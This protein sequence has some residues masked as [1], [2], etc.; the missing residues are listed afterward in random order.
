MGTSAQRVLAALAE[1]A[2]VM[3]SEL[4]VSLE[5][6]VGE[7]TIRRSSAQLREFG[8]VASAATGRGAR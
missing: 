3:L 5:P 6:D 1:A 7:R 2:P 8:A 4:V